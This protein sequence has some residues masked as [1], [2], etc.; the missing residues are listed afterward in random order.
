MRDERGRYITLKEISTNGPEW[1]KGCPKCKFGVAASAPLT[2]ADHLYF[3]RLVQA[4]D[5]DLTFCDCR[6]GLLAKQY[7]KRLYRQTTSQDL[8][9]ARYKV[10]AARESAPA[11]TVHMESETREKVTA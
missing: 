4:S 9:T 2:G 11:P 7:M 10:E 8:G 3:E 1:A 6:A 5:G